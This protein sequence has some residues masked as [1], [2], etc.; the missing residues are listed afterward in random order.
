[1]AV[2][3]LE[4]VEEAM[5]FTFL[6]NQDVHQRIG[7]RFYKIVSKEW[8]LAHQKGEEGFRAALYADYRRAGT[9]V[10]GLL[11]GK[12]KLRYALYEVRTWGLT[13]E[14]A[15]SLQETFIA[16]VGEGLSAVWTPRPD[17]S[18]TVSNVHWIY[19]GRVSEYEEAAKRAYASI[20]LMVPYRS[21]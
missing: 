9:E 14:D 2:V 3:T 15:E 13:V 17:L 10:R 1:M 21:D 12:S 19:D 16:V 20:G 8:A 18:V 5:V 7:T 11:G 6:N 4:D